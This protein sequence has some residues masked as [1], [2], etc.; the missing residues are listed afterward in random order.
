MIEEDD[1]NE[2]APPGFEIQQ[3]VAGMVPQASTDGSRVGNSSLVL[4]SMV[5]KGTSSR[6]SESVQ[7]N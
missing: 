2:F 1:E 5:L 3:P 6:N 4:G 7:R